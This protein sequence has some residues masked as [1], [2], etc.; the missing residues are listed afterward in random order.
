MEK[1]FLMLIKANDV[2]RILGSVLSVFTRRRINILAITYSTNSTEENYQE[3]QLVIKH[4]EQELKKM[5]LQIEKIVEVESV[6]IS[7]N[8]SETIKPVLI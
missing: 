2:S 7:E 3:I 4:D 6:S 5:A 8:K 1:S